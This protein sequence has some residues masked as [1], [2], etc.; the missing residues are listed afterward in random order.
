M[1]LSPLW[2]LVWSRFFY[3]SLP[4]MFIV[5]F[6]TFLWERNLK[7]VFYKMKHFPSKARYRNTD[8]QKINFI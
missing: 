3:N 5:I 6:Q 1:V 4:M 7:D 2:D 8:Q